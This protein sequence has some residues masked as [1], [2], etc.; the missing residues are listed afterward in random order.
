MKILLISE[1]FPSSEKAD[2]TGGVESRCFNVAKRLAKK[3]KVKIITSY[4]EGLK[5]Y[6]KFC[7]IEVYRVGKYHSYSSSGNILSRLDFAKNAEKKGIEFNDIDIIDGYSFLTYLPSYS[8]AKKLKKPCIITY[9]ET[10]VG[11][12]IKTK[13]LITGI[14]GE[15][16]E[17]K[18]LKRKFDKII[19]V[20]KF[21]KRRLIE[22]GI[23]EKNIVIIPNGVDLK[24]F[25]E[26]KAKKF[27]QPTICCISRLTPKKKI[28][29]LIKAV[30]VVRIKIPDI[31]CKI[32]GQ[33]DEICN[34][35]KLVNQSN[36]NENIEFLGF[37]EK[38]EDVIK[39][40]K[41][42]HVFC[43][44]SILEGFGMVVI[45]AMASQ[46][47]YICS[48]IEPL[49][50]VTENG[51]GGLLFKAEDYKDLAEKIMK[52][53]KDKKLYEKKVKE[54]STLVKKYDWDLITKEI[55]KVYDGLVG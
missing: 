28:D 2:I 43:L 32:I 42:S 36:L 7:N 31:K 8:I 5:R 29:D 18:V 9:H 53:L 33:G 14:P 48:D 21:T 39:I 37:V 27:S 13:G 46:V 34:L 1:Y 35:K 25:N 11:E 52:L 24:Q 54:A 49:K 40:L 3:H 17:R 55:E 19:S 41:S 12:W 10:W 15:I 44:P 30:D 47:P 20:S 38:N 45:E 26:I 4:Q 16:W 51:K 6:D 22:R 23:N 50:E